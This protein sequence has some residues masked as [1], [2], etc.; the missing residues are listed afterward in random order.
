LCSF[1]PFVY[2]E[3]NTRKTCD[4]LRKA[5]PQ[6][7]SVCTIGR[8]PGSKLPQYKAFDDTNRVFIIDTSARSTTMAGLDLPETDIILF[9]RLGEGGHIDT[10]KIVQSIG[11]AIRAQKK[12]E[13]ENKRDHAHYREHGHS[14]HAP[15]IVVFID[16]FKKRA[17]K[18]AAPAAPP[19][20]P[21]APP[22][23]AVAPPADAGPPGE[24]QEAGP[25]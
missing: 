12:G 4:F 11:R 7:T 22:P 19:P 24:E 2:Q 14:R 17:P 20:A 25:P 8:G 9:D 13:A 23:A 1:A 18:P 3:R 21:V 16:K 5:V 15:K 6:L 10:A